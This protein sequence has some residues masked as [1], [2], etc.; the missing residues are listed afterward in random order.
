VDSSFTTA[1]NFP[2]SRQPHHPHA[3]LRTPTS[4]PQIPPLSRSMLENG[5]PQLLPGQTLLLAFRPAR[6]APGMPSAKEHTPD[7]GETL[8]AWWSLDR[9]RNDYPRCMPRG[10]GRTPIRL[11]VPDIG[12]GR[13][14]SRVRDDAASTVPAPRP[15]YPTSILEENARR[16]VPC[17]RVTGCPQAYSES[18]STRS[19]QPVQGF[20]RT[21]RLIPMYPSLK[22]TA[23]HQFHLGPLNVLTSRSSGWSQLHHHGEDD[24]GR[25]ETSYQ[26]MKALPRNYDTPHLLKIP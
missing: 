3:S 24:H 20:T 14:S 16:A 19:H 13:R 11:V 8:L 4:S 22:T 1:R 18:S 12:Q 10:R 17:G 7:E 25:R 23:I 5:F 2:F 6:L 21:H 26:P 15:R 9:R